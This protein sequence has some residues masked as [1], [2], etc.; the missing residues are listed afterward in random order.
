MATE[1]ERIANW[2]VDYH[3]DN[4]TRNFYSE[5]VK[6][7]E[8]QAHMHAHEKQ[9]APLSKVSGY[10]LHEASDDADM[11]RKTLRKIIRLSN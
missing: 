11:D 4:G 10:E 7:T 8:E 2:I 9:Y 3:R 1:R 6:G 5:I